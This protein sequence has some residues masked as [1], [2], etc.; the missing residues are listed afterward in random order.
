MSKFVAMGDIVESNGKTVRENNLE[1]EH[2]IPVGTL[3]EV[4]YTNWFGDG[5]CEKVQARLFVVHRGRDC[6]GSPLYWLSKTPLEGQNDIQ[7]I[8]FDDGHHRWDTPRDMSQRMYY[9]WQGGF[10]ED[11]LTVLEVT[12]ELKLGQ[13][14]LEWEQ[15]SRNG[16]KTENK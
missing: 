16:T 12:E 9:G 13:H 8:S 1:R 2:N 10:P 6:D 7:T 3:V 11:A 5:A 14:A 4:Q 15:P